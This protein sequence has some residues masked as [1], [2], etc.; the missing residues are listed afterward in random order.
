MNQN[1]QNTQNTSIN[2]K[3]SKNNRIL[4]PNKHKLLYNGSGNV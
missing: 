3:S 2:Q 1:T 4:D